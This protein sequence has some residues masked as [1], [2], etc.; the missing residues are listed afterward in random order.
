[1]TSKDLCNLVTQ[2]AE[3]FGLVIKTKDINNHKGNAI[4]REFLDPKGDNE[5]GVYFGYISPSQNYG[6]PYADYSFVVFPD[7]L[8]NVRYCVVGLGVGLLGFES[9]NELAQTPGLR[10][11]YLTLRTLEQQ[12]S[13]YKNDFSDI[14]STLSDLVKDVKEHEGLLS[15]TIQKYKTVIQAC[16]VI[17]VSQDDGQ[18]NDVGLNKLYCWL[19]IYGNLRSWGIAENQKNRKTWL[20]EQLPA[21][22][23]QDVLKDVMNLLESDRFVVLQGAPG[24]GKTYTASEIAK[25][26]VYRDH[27]IFTQFNAETTYSDF[28]Y[29]LQPNVSNEKEGN[30]GISFHATK[31]PLYEAIDKAQKYNGPVLLII[32]EINRAN[33]SNVLGP[34]FYLFEKDADERGLKIKVGDKE[35][36]SLPKNLRVLATMNTADRSLAVVDF[37]LRRRF[38]WYTIKPQIIQFPRSSQYKFRKKE[39][40]GM[41]EIFRQ[42]ATDAELNLQPGPSYFIVKNDEEGKMEKEMEQRMEYELMPLIKEYLNEQFL[43]NASDAFSNYFIENCNKLLYE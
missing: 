16:A 30:V 35:L 26:E 12:H 19:A 2:K 43:L 41:A 11:E 9:D 39:F 10:R 27:V 7:S 15:N 1:M 4:K 8:E 13:Y 29:G 40:E 14:R 21:A 31:G 6:G 25:N 42:Y 24:T 37:A 32:D 3:Y 28:I 20:Q 23:N 38:V 36:T 33:L 5:N 18:V 34:V 22:Q 17:K